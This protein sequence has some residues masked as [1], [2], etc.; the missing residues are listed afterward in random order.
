MSALSIVHTYMLYVLRTFLLPVKKGSYVTARY[1]YFFEKDK[2]NIKYFWGSAVL[3]HLFHNL[4][5]ASRADGKQ[6]V[7]YTT[8]LMSWIFSQFPK[9]PDL[10]NQ[11][12]SDAVE[13]C[14][15]WKWGLS[16]T[17]RTGARDLLKY[18]EVFDNYK[19]ED[20]VWDPYRAERSSEAGSPEAERLKK[21]ENEKKTSSLITEKLTE[22]VTE[23]EQL[24]VTIEQMKEDRTLNDVVHEQFTKSFEELPTK[25]E[26][27][28]KE[29]KLL[30]DI[31]AK[32]ADQSE[33]Q[34]LTPV[35]EAWRQAI[36]KEFHS[37]ELEDK[38]DPTFIELFDQYDRFYTIVHQGPK[39]DYQDDF[40][41]TGE[42]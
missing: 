38:D 3:A 39:G 34:H 22:K 9:L 21:Q 35:L 12:H 4:G 42:N 24:R 19:V 20:V 28:R 8:L 37:G 27:K 30:Q 41:V 10:P 11:Q 13:Y 23:Y 36:K 32:L 15:W 7:A 6:F 1:L 14:T 2:A 26:E 18:R 5:A 31:N 40:T 33:R 25:L 17:E 29:Y 16:I